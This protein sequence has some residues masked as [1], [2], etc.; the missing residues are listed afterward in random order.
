MGEGGFAAAWLLGTGIGVYRQVTRSHRMPVPGNILALQ[1]FFAALALIGDVIPNARR[2]TV[3]LAW[4]LD[5]AG[6]L[7]LLSS[8]PLSGQVATAQAS[9]ATAESP[10]ATGT[11]QKPGTSTAGG[12][13]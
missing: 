12:R 9:E 13:G 6:I 5:I 10:I 3:L 4:S 7:Q 11:T 8:G 2:V 1:A